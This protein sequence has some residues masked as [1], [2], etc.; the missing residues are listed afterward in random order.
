MKS[1]QNRWSRWI[2]LWKKLICFDY[3]RRH[4]MVD[5]END[6]MTRLL[7]FQKVESNG[8]PFFKVVLGLHCSSFA[9]NSRSTGISQLQAGKTLSKRPCSHFL[10]T[11]HLLPYMWASFYPLDPS[12]Y[13]SSFSS[14]RPKSKKIPFFTNL[15]CSTRLFLAGLLQTQFWSHRPSQ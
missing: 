7:L 8:V 11:G 12:R 3:R 5:H 1:Y 13:L 15:R 14:W 4:I 10:S 6:D 9:G 2:A